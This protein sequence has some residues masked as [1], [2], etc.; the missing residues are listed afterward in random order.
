MPGIGI[1]P[2]SK[3]A[4]REIHKQTIDQ[5]VDQICPCLNGPKSSSWPLWSEGARASTRKGAGPGQKERL[6]KGPH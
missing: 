1:P 4:A 2:L 5:M 6:C 3:N